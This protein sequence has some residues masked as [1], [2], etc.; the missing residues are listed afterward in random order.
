[1]KICNFVIFD[2]QSIENQTADCNILN[3][4]KRRWHHTL[5]ENRREY[6]ENVMWPLKDSFGGESY[7]DLTFWEVTIIPRLLDKNFMGWSLHVAVS[8]LLLEVFRTAQ[9]QIGIFHIF[10]RNWHP[11][12]K[13][14]KSEKVLFPLLETIGL[15]EIKTYLHTC[16]V[17]PSCW[18][19]F[20]IYPR[21]FR[22]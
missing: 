2:L 13:F 9:L 17:D 11:F 5:N 3:V 12:G 21:S 7:T 14:E 15:Y 16:I 6:K 4:A 22:H 10:W 8:S 1:M 20:Q 19:Q 18:L